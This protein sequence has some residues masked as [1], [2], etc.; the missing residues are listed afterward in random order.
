MKKKLLLSVLS[1]SALIG[2]SGCNKLDVVGDTSVKSFDAVLKT[3]E[4]QLAIDEANNSW[5]LTAPDQSVRFVWSSDYSKTQNYDAFLETDAKPFID[6][7]LDASKLPEGMLV[8]DKI[9]VGTEFGND[10]LTYEGDVTALKS[11]EQIVKLYRDS[12]KYHAALDHYGVDLMNGNMFEWA[13]DMSKN[14]KDIVYVLNPQVFIEAGVD[15]QK[16]EGWVFAKVET[17]DDKGKK[18]EVDKFLKPFDLDGKQ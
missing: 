2:L 8:G 1:L 15:P 18:I 7:G 10:K 17:M 11:Y 9:I 12:V 4:Y 14:D 16:V 6:A 13:K 5:S 3:A